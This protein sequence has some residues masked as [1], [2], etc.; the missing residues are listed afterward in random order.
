MRFSSVEVMVGKTQGRCVRN[1]EGF[2]KWNTIP[3]RIW[4]QENH[5]IPNFVSQLQHQY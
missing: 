4:N 2:L 3:A 1:I 5:H